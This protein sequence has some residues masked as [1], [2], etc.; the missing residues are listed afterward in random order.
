MKPPTIDGSMAEHV[1]V[2]SVGDAFFEKRCMI[3]IFSKILK[4]TITCDYMWGP[5]ITAIRAFQ[6]I[7]MV[8]YFVLSEFNLVHGKELTQRAIVLLFTFCIVSAI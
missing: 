8:I 1:L 7:F 3:G 5:S 6:R 2:H 4:V